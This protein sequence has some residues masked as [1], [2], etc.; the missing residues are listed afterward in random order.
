MLIRDV[1]PRK[2]Y[3]L[4]L[5]LSC[6]TRENVFF[7]CQLFKY[8]KR[9][10]ITTEAEYTEP[11]FRPE[12]FTSHVI[13]FAFLIWVLGI[14]FQERYYPEMDT[15]FRMWPHHIRVERFT[16]SVYIF[17]NT[18]RDCIYIWAFSLFLFQE[19]K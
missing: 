10:T 1:T 7:P 11:L 16:C 14:P 6:A 3:L 8:L 13:S 17:L 15:P 12:G 19:I 5:I 2:V 9:E 4:E 18:T